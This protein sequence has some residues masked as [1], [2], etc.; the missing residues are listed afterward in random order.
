MF[1]RQQILMPFEL[2]SA[3]FHFSISNLFIDKI[4]D[5]VTPTYRPCHENGYDKSCCAGDP[6]SFVEV[7]FDLEDGNPVEECQEQEGARVEVEQQES[8]GADGT[9]RV[10]VDQA[11]SDTRA[12]AKGSSLTFLDELFFSQRGLSYDKEKRHL[13]AP[14][15]R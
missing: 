4:Y 15:Q 10:A 14:I 2:I 12:T 8:V 11:D 6:P 7:P 5:L 1:S 3:L 13:L 9:L